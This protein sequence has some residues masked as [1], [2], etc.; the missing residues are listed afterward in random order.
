MKKIETL[1]QSEKW[2][3]MREQLSA[4]GVRGT[5]REVN[6]FGYAPPTRGVYRGTSYLMNIAPGLEL[7][8]VVRDEMLEQVS[9]LLEAN[10]SGEILV[11][12]AELIEAS[13]PPQRARVV[14]RAAL[15]EAATHLRN[16]V[17][18]HT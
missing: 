15:A 1:V 9:A 18:S 13:A 12:P 11:S 6:T 5:L 17:F 10:G 7:A 16:R 8:L 2:E 14:Q 3:S 4:L